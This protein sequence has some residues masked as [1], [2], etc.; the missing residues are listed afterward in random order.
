MNGLPTAIKVEVI[1]KLYEQGHWL[2]RDISHD[3]NSAL[4]IWIDRQP[5]LFN[6]LD[7]GNLEEEEEY[8]NAHIVWRNVEFNFND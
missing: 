7:F 8:L 2:P 5:H 1:D 6:V 4:D 3:W